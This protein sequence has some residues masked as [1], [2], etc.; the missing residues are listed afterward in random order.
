MAALVLVGPATPGCQV[1]GPRSLG[2]LG[3]LRQ[4]QAALKAEQ[5]ERGV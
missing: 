1:Q 4:T 2:L 5:S 3:C